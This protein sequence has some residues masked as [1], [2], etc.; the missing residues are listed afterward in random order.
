VKVFHNQKM[1]EFSVLTWNTAKRLKH[2][3]GQVE[4]IHKL[5]PDI[6]ALQEIIP[7]TE[8]KLRSLLLK[9]YPHILS[10]FELVKD[11]SNLVK[12]R[13]FGQ[14][15]ASRF[16]LRAINPKKFNIPWTERV[17]S[18]TALLGDLTIDL[19]TTHIPPGSSNGWLKVEMIDGIVQYFKDHQENPQILCGDFNT[20]QKE[21]VNDGVITFAQR[22]KS[23]GKVVLR[24]R[25]RGGLGADWDTS[26]RS[27]FTQLNSHGLRDAYRLQHPDNFDAF[28][29]LFHRK[30]KEFKTRFDH[31]FVDKRLHL[32]TCEFINDQGSLSDHAPLLVKMYA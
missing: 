2:A 32:Q 17:L 18:V 5:S 30:G 7:S 19:H 21:T 25:F 22:I 3:P 27:L 14:L 31:M 11:H 8:Q 23:D 13:M 20:P 16:P 15:I 4:F 10:S 6:I 1:K 28:S 9:T 12:K 26:E 29:W 24:N